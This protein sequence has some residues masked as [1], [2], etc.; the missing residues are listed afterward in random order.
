MVKIEPKEQRPQTFQSIEIATKWDEEVQEPVDEKTEAQDDDEVQFE[1][2]YDDD[3]SDAQNFVS[4][5]VIRLR[6]LAYKLVTYVSLQ[7]LMACSASAR[8]RF[9]TLQPVVF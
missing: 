3:D 9:S 5:G 1:N 8:W 6:Q 4:R 7:L 2:L